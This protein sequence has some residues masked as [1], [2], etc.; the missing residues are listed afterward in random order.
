MPHSPELPWPGS[1]VVV[2]FTGHRPD[3]LG[4]Y[5]GD[6]PVAR[7]VRQALVQIVLRTV[8]KYPG[9]VF[10]C[11]MA[12]GVDQW[13]AEAV[14]AARE[15]GLPCRLEAVVPFE[16]QQDRWPRP[17]REHYL[18]LLERADLVHVLWYGPVHSHGQAR[19]LLLA[20]NRWMV[21]RASVLLA[22]W[23]GSPGGTGHTVRLALERGLTVVRFD[24]RSPELGWQLLAAAPWSS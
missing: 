9:A 5:R 15:R 3:K 24:P 12:L 14:L 23:D 7:R 2:A 16:G 13:A 17:A 21:E 18:R 20:R 11:G 8:R 19:R 22:V 1:P 4:G 10:V 6:S